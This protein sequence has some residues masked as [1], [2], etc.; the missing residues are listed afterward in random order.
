M[1]HWF[2]VRLSVSGSLLAAA[3]VVGG[4]P[5]GVRWRG[6]SLQ[7][8]VKL[9]MGSLADFLLSMSPGAPSSAR[10]KRTARGDADIHDDD[11]GGSS[12][13]HVDLCAFKDP[14]RLASGPSPPAPAR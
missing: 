8:L 14:S 6:G 9:A 5:F 3:A 10:A 1:N 7:R 2:H 4:I 11:H 12:V 13:K